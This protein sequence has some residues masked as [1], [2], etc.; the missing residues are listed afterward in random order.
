M[1][2]VVCCS[3]DLEDKILKAICEVKIGVT[4]VAACVL[5]DFCRYIVRETQE[6]EDEMGNFRTHRPRPNTKF[7]F[8]MDDFASI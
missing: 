2:W 6:E 7:Y 5:V 3:V 8:V 1:I 4:I